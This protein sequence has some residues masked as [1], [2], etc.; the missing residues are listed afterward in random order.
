M[1][2]AT[3]T[4]L[5]SQKKYQATV[6]FIGALVCGEAIHWLITPEASLSSNARWWAVIAQAVFGAS[7][8]PWALYRA[9]EA[10]VSKK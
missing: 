9:R 6:A 5:T 1:G 8:V 2:E 7:L 4:Q 3:M 10:A